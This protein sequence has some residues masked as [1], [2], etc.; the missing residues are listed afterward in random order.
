MATKVRNIDFFFPF[1]LLVC[2]NNNYLGKKRLE[3]IWR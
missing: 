3:M 2:P 1:S